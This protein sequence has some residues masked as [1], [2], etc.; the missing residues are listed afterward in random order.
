MY[1]K[2]Q[3]DEGD[4]RIN[5]THFFLNFKIRKKQFIFLS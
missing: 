2:I 1:V 4:Y 3:L 5:H